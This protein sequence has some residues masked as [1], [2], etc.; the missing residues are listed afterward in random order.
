MLN[1]F[2]EVTLEIL[3][4][5]PWNNLVHWYSDIVQTGVVEGTKKTSPEGLHL[6]INAAENNLAA[7]GT[8]TT[9][10]DGVEYKQPANGT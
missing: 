4:P 3:L 2:E 1:G 9:T 5:D 10:L 6:E 8:L 7:N